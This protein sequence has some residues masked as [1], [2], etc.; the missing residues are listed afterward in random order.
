MGNRL[1]SVWQG[2][3]RRLG[4]DY[5]PKVW[6]LDQSSPLRYLLFV[7]FDAAVV[8]EGI[9]YWTHDGSLPVELRKE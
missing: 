2:R 3:R 9:T 7:I 6:N 5:R 8:K 4:M 1:G